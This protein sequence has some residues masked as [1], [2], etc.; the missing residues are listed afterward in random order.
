VALIGSG[1]A[2]VICP[3]TA[4]WLERLGGLPVVRQRLR[5]GRHVRISRQPRNVITL[6][7]SHG[8]KLSS[9]KIQ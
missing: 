8:A 9:I 7:L 5:D 6:S 4:Y 2:V 3:E 1:G